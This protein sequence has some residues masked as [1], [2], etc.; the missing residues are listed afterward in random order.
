MSDRLGVMDR[1]RLLQVGTPLEIYERPRTPF[2]A[3]FIGD[4]NLIAGTVE[5]TDRDTVI[6]RAGALRIRTRGHGWE[7]AGAAV[8]VCIR[9]E[10]LRVA[11]PDTSADGLPGRVEDRAFVGQA[12]KYRV[13]VGGLQ[14]RATV[15]YERGTLLFGIG[16]A[17]AVRWDP[18]QAVPVP[19]DEGGIGNEDAPDLRD[20]RPA[21]PA[22]AR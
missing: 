7:R 21:G 16:D 3:Q 9:P 8:S 5:A 6:V 18:A 1:G 22:R 13:D 17:V 11:A 14:L 2:V 20:I 15:P 19:A 4:A 12:V 10:R